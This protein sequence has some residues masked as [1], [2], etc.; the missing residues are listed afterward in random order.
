MQTIS[1]E[2][3]QPYAHP[4]V[5]DDHGLYKAKGHVNRV[6]SLPYKPSLGPEAG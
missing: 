5:N 3:V 4:H 6:A 1:N 2:A